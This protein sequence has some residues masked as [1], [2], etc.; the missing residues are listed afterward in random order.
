MSNKML[1][2]GGAGCIGSE[3]TNALLDRGHHVT[4]LDNL[5]SGRRERLEDLLG[6]AR[7]RFCEGDVLDADALNDAMAGAEMVWHLAANP[8]VKF[9]PG[10]ATDKDLKQN[11]L[12][13]HHVLEAMRRHEIKRLAFASTSAVYGL[14]DRLPISEDQAPL[15]ISLYGASKLAC[16]ALIGAFQ[17][18]FEMQVWIFRFANIVGPK[19]RTRGRTVI[20]DFIHKLRQDP[21]QLKILGNGKQAK[22][23]LLNSE[24]VDAMLYVVENAQDPLNL[25]N[26]GCD[27]WLSVDRI[28]ELV[29]DAMGLSAVSFEYTGTEGGW[30]GDVP[31]F[32]LDVAALNRLGWKATHNSEEAVC[33]AIRAALERPACSR[34]GSVC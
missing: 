2:T 20:G 21:T 8:D 12:A 14:C 3:L 23:Y 29:V 26:L 11:T 19:V 13:T 9:T 4:V 5:S 31:R 27:D 16:E 34:E 18:L 10:D 17:H 32:L 33:I 15:P 7:F 1:V 30:P 22:S 25:F 6:H 28:A 24:C